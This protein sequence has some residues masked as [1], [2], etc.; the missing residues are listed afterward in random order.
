MA[1]ANDR[2]DERTRDFQ[3]PGIVAET[4]RIVKAKA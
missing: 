1:T 3:A 2:W 4:L